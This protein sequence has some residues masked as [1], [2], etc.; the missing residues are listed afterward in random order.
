MKKLILG[1]L[2]LV[3]ASYAGAQE[4]EVSLS[5]AAY[6]GLAY[7]FGGGS[8]YA[9]AAG[10][11]SFQVAGRESLG[12][13]NSIIF[14]LQNGF[15]LTTGQQED[16]SSFW[17]MQAWVG[18]QGPWGTLR[19]GRLYAPA[20][21]TYALVAD[22]DMGFSVISANLITEINTVRQNNGIEYNS[23][24]FNPWTYGHQGFYF[25]L[26]HY[27]GDPS[28][29]DGTN[30]G[31][32]S[33]NTTDGGHV[34]YAQGRWIVEFAAQKQNTYTSAT[35]NINSHL[36]FL[37][38]NYR[39]D[40]AT[41]YLAYGVASA[42]NRAT[43]TGTA[44]SQEFLFSV[45]IPIGHGNLIANYIRFNDKFN[46]DIAHQVGVLYDY[47]MSKRT[48]LTAGYVRIGNSN[49]NAY[50]LYNGYAN[51]IPGQSP[52]RNSSVTLGITHYF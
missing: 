51:T 44:N 16:P 29:M 37:A 24:G 26:A 8:G 22:P 34:G 27:F 25:T 23:P 5:G 17:D 3:S 6:G 42:N 20:F 12:G 2:A 48:K 39:F 13:G 36:V 46:H 35:S 19:A 21:D 38:S 50:Q 33:R 47:Y 9:T 28:A 1:T 7:N 52:P 41:I 10:P 43:N 14:K 15:Y 31:P 18:A 11:S 49:G 30:P 32:A 45:K 4:S 40:F